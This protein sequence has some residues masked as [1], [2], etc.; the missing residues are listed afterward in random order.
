LKLFEKEFN[1]IPVQSDK[2]FKK[3]IAFGNTSVVSLLRY[4]K[5][6]DM[7]FENKENIK[8]DLWRVCI[9]G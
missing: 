9:G 7:V 3:M 8:R 2:N 1:V 6:I 4:N 5:D